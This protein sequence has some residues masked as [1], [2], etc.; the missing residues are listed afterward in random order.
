MK[1][2]CQ[3]KDW[4]HYHSKECLLLKDMKFFN[5]QMAF[6]A[7]LLKRKDPDTFAKLMSLESSNCSS[8]THVRFQKVP[9]GHDRHVLWCSFVIETASQSRPSLCKGNY[10]YF[11]YCKLYSCLTL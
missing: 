1:K 3:R 10:N 8:W 6:R 11:M 2:D 7:A 4:H 9:S 5:I